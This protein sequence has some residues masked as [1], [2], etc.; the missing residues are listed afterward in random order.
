MWLI[1]RP[2]SG[3]NPLIVS[4]TEAADGAVEAFGAFAFASASGIQLLT[5]SANMKAL[6][7]GGPVEL[8]IGIDAITD[9][10][11]IDAF[12]AAG[13]LYPNLA[14]AVFVHKKAGSIFH[15]KV[16]CFVYPDGTGR[17]LTGS[18]NLTQGGL[19]LNWEAFSVQNLDVAA[20]S[21]LKSEWGTWKAGSANS[22]KPVDDHEVAALAN[23][24]KLTRQK[25]KRIAEIAVEQE[26][27]VDEIVAE[28]KHQLG[29]NRMLIAEVPRNKNRLSQVG[30]DKST[31][32][33]Y[34]GVDIDDGKTIYLHPVGKD[35][36]VGALEVSEA[37]SVKSQNFRFEVRGVVGPYPND[38]PILI[39]ESVAEDTFNYLFIVPGDDGYSAIKDWLDAGHPKER[40]MRRIETTAPVLASVWPTCPIL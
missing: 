23:R 39:F 31:Y 30:F 28:I 9:T 13:M 33:G 16:M 25:L 32:Q 5:S 40:V 27:A 7:A 29:L 17:A 1:Q 18:G 37:V 15:P 22:L 4:L 34:F 11:A 12:K 3:A 36:Q 24:N 19:K 38:R 35:G 14:V 10:S 2:D 26:D 8:V 21:Q 20:V 6:L